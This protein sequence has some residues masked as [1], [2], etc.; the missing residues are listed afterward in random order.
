M[1]I[2]KMIIYGNEDELAQA[3]RYSPPLNEIDEFGY[4]PLIQTA[5][6]NSVSKAKLLIAAGADVNFTDLTGRTPLHWASDNNNYE[7]VKLLLE[8]RANPNVYTRAG[9]P[10][11]AMPVLRNYKEIKHL[12]YQY[13]ASLDFAQD[14][15]NAKLLGHRFELEGRVDIVDT[16]NTFIEVEFEGFYTEFS[17][18]IVVNSLQDFINNFGAKHLREYFNCFEIII[19]SYKTAQSLLKYQHYLVDKS[20]YTATIDK[21][22]NIKSLII[23]VSFGGHAITLVK[24][25]DHLIRCDRGAYGR[26]H[27]TVIIYKIANKHLVTK[28]FLRN[29]IYKRQD[30]HFING[31]LEQFLGLTVVETLPLSTQLTGNCSWAN[32]EAAVLALLYFLLKQSTLKQSKILPKQHLLDQA[33]YIYHEWLEWDKN[34]ALYFCI[35][36][37]QPASSARRASKAAIL[38]AIIFQRCDAEVLRDHMTAEKILNILGRPEYIELLKIYIKVFSE[39]RKN[40]QLK[41][42]AEFLEYA[43]FDFNRLKD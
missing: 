26:D 41:N 32:I 40:T 1:S 29:L 7:F 8:K 36:S 37:F 34:R 39:D 16:N 25:G 24:V 10:I 4:T 31:G 12:L 19:D 15:I 18:Q 33:S 22:L 35:Q 5:I 23:P 11:L 2:A 43:G 9:Q 27:G 28:S 3:L 30:E 21:L 42:L 20:R 17:L 13:G 6:T 14:F 38:A